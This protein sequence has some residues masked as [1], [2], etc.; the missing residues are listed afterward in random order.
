MGTLIIILVGLYFIVSLVWPLVKKIAPKFGTGDAVTARE[1]LEKWL[2]RFVDEGEWVDEEDEKGT[3]ATQKAIKKG[4]KRLRQAGEKAVSGFRPNLEG[5][6]SVAQVMSPRDALGEGELQIK[7]L[8]EET[9]PS[10]SQF[11]PTDKKAKRELL[12][13]GVVLKE[14]LDTKY[15]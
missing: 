9:P 12:R 4:A 8:E 13:E 11:L 5:T 1:D 10:S 7:I 2:R 14:I 15:F 6:P 3:K